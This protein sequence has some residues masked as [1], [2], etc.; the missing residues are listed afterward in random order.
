ME[1][2]GTF[3]LLR[4]YLFP[5]LVNSNVAA[6]LHGGGGGDKKRFQCCPVSLKKLSST[7]VQYKAVLEETKLILRCN[8]T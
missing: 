7:N 5:E 2:P 4:L 6:P 8:T 3:V 1:N